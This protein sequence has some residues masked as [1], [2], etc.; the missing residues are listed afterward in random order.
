MTPDQFAALS[1]L[2]EQREAPSRD[3]ARLVLVEG[4][5]PSEAAD[6]AGVSRQAVSNVLRRCRRVIGLAER[7]AGIAAT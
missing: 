1:E 3:A 5:S 6:R 4:I 2:M 7:V